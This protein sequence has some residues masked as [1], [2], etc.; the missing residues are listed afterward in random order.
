MTQGIPEYTPKKGGRR[1]KWHDPSPAILALDFTGLLYRIRDAHPEGSLNRKQGRR[2]KAWI[3]DTWVISDFRMGRTRLYTEQWGV[4][5]KRLE[6]G[7]F[8]VTSAGGDEELCL[9]EFTLMR[10]LI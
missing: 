2:Y 5:G 3:G 9:R 1:W 6:T 7:Q 4:C 8:L 10:V